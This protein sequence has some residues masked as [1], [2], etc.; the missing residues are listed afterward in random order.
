MK[1]VPRPVILRD[2]PRRA[3]IRDQACCVCPP[4]KQSEPTE[5][6]HVHTKRNAGDDH[7][8]IPLCRRHHREQ[9]QLGVETFAHRNGVDLEKSAAWYWD[10]YDKEMGW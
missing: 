9:H 6:A 1:P 8:L 2:P 4:G 10:A 5:C 7:N 3:W